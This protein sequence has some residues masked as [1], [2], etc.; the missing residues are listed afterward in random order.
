MNN[1]SLALKATTVLGSAQVI[2][3]LAG[4]VVVKFISVFIGPSGIGYNGLLQ[5]IMVL[6]IGIS[7]IGLTTSGVQALS[8]VV[9]KEPN[10]FKKLTSIVKSLVDIISYLGVL[11]MIILSPIIAYYAFSDIGNLWTVIY[12]SLAVYFTH[13]SSFF[14]IIY[15]S[16]NQIGKIGKITLFTSLVSIVTSALLIYFYRINGILPS[17]IILSI[18]T[19]IFNKVYYVKD[20]TIPKLSLVKSLTVGKS[21]LQNG[22]VI[23]LGGFMH[24]FVALALR[25]YISSIANLTELGLFVAGITLVNA[26]VGVVFSAMATDYFPRLCT[27]KIKDDIIDACSSQAEVALLFISPLIGVL[28]TYRDLIITILYSDAFLEI[29]FFIVFGVLGLFF[30]AL[31]W[32]KAYIILAKGD[33]KLFL[34]LEF[35]SAFLM[36]F[37]IISGYNLYGLNGAGFGLLLLCVIY[38]VVIEIVIL[39]K[40]NISFNRKTYFTFLITLTFSLLVALNIVLFKM[41]YFN[42]VVIFLA[43]LYSSFKLLKIF[44]N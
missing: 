23:A 28:L 7:G 38:F 19:Y 5:S 36:L 33:M 3:I 21:I 4:I 9:S 29:G 24:L 2:K 10:E 34:F 14:Q 16:K 35:L 22:F 17:I 43:I 44:K 12:L 18:L 30:K 1:K 41:L 15:Q 31:S 25:T 42:E 20:T 13:K 32:S 37:L 26:Y 6:A 11:L 39:I 40:Y 27:L 8:S